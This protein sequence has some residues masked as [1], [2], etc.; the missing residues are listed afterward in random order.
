MKDYS[1]LKS[2]RTE[3]LNVHVG[4]R[5]KDCFTRALGGAIITP[6]EVLVTF[7]RGGLRT[8][9]SMEVPRILRPCVNKGGRVAP[10]GGWEG[11]GRVGCTSMFGDG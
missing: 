5:G 7:L 8:S 10:G 6:P 11:V 4:K 2:T 3:E 1:G 9:N